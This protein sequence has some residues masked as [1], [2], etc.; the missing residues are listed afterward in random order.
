MNDHDLDFT[1]ERLGDC[2]FPS[3]MQK[4]RLPATASGSC[5]TPGSMK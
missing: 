1:I 3:P 4:V 5:T 2:R